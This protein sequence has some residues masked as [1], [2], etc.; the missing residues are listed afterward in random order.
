M[1]FGAATWVDEL[2]RQVVARLATATRLPADCVFETLARDD[3]HLMFPPS[4]RFIAVTPTAFP[5]DAPGVSGGGRLT[6]GFNGRFR[7][8]LFCRIASD[9]ELRD[10]RL[11]RDRVGGA[12]AVQLLVLGALQQFQPLNSDGECLLREPMR[13]EGWDVQ[14]KSPKQGTP[15]A[16]IASTWSL[17]FTSRIAA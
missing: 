15:W 6:T 12:L 10:G 7:T 11:L 13:V 1:T 2:L 8:A 14:P 17:K 3:D 9:Q 5:V 4:D 16:V